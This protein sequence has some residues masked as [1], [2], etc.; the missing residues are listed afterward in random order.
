MK[1]LSAEQLDFLF[2]IQLERVYGLF[3]IAS[4][5]LIFEETSELIA[6]D[7]Q[8]QMPWL[9]MTG[10]SLRTSQ[11]ALNGM[12]L[13]GKSQGNWRKLPNRKLTLQQLEIGT[14]IELLPLE[15]KLWMSANGRKS[16]EAI[17]QD[18]DRPLEQ[19]Q[20]AANHLLMAG[21]VKE[22]PQKSWQK[23]KLSSS[24]PNNDVS[25][26]SEKFSPDSLNRLPSLERLKPKRWQKWCKNAIV[27]LGVTGVTVACS[28][29]GIFQ[30]SELEN[31]DRFFRWR[32]LEVADRRIAIVTINDTDIKNVGQ[33]PISDTKLAQALRNLQKH[34]PKAIGLDIYRDIPVEPGHEELLQVYQNTPNLIGI[35]KIAGKDKVSPPP[36]LKQ[37]DQVAITD[38][39]LDLDGKVRRSLVSVGS[40]QG[41]LFSLGVYLALIYLQDKGINLESVGDNGSEYKLGDALFSP[42]TANTGGYVGNDV[43]GYQIMLNYRSNPDNFE[44]ISFTD[45]VANRISPE[46]IRDRLVLIG[47]NADSLKDFFATPFSYDRANTYTS[48][49]GVFIHANV[50]SQIISAALDGRPLLNSWDESR[51]WLWILGWAVA[52]TILARK[53]LKIKPSK[54]QLAIAFGL[55]LV[56]ASSAIGIGYLIF[57]VG[58]WVP[59]VTPS[60]A[61]T[62]SIV[63]LMLGER[64]RQLQQQAYLDSKTQLVNRNYF[65]RYLEQQ[66]RSARKK[67]SYLSLI[68]VD[69]ERL[70]LDRSVD[71][72]NTKQERLRQ[73]SEAIESVVG[74]RDSLV[75]RYADKKFAIV[76]PKTKTQ[77]AMWKAEKIVARIKSLQKVSQPSND[78]SE[79]FTASYGIASIV[80]TDESSATELMA[81][82]DE[83]LRSKRL[84]VRV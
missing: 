64:D 18:L 6:K 60:I 83:A 59:V 53:I 30:P 37:L 36:V 62:A 73:T 13:V 26:N 41:Q 56:A 52:G 82:A 74:E 8:I 1:L 3:E 43:G 58:W 63:L 32:P 48:S 72:T 29:N 44:T 21:L 23:R 79:H 14:D 80:P 47:A 27:A 70:Q 9:E 49:P 35:E 24:L 75:A 7:N 10:R 19:I 50:T 38:T 67:N 57:L 40:E 68:F 15:S 51:E 55:Y 28:L 77:A 39:V 20:K 69:V 61:L 81:M 66:W 22:V 4:G 54:K 78:S 33:W 25:S 65:E 34:N 12:R 42:L 31:L 11:L 45:V 71:S 5:R 17:A 16:L 2:Q 84:G 46:L 76:L